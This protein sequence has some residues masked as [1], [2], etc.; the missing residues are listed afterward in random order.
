M[1]N[2][3]L[4]LRTVVRVSADD[5]DDVRGKLQISENTTVAFYQ[6]GVGIKPLFPSQNLLGGKQ[7]EV[8]IFCTLLFQL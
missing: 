2:L 7:W 5:A 8:S 3:C 6:Y 1:Q 4:T